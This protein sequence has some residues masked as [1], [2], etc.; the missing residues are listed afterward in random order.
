MQA[1]V[2]LIRIHRNSNH[3]AAEFNLGIAFF[4]GVV[5]QNAAGFEIQHGS[6]KLELFACDFFVT[7]LT[8]VHDVHGRHSFSKRAQVSPVCSI[9]IEVDFVKA[10]DGQTTLDVQ[11]ML[12]VHGH[13]LRFK[14][15]LNCVAG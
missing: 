15:T 2:R 4:A 14:C 9:Q 11:Q 8:G 6:K 5:Y 12:M 3:L 13:Y 1:V 10:L 7:R